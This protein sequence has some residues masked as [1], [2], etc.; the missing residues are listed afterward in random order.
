MQ[1]L[2]ISETA[3]SRIA[4]KWL[5]QPRFPDKD[6]FTSSHLGFVLVTPITAKTQKQQNNVGRLGSSKWK[7]AIEGDWEHP[8][9]TA[10]HQ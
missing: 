10:S 1:N 3:E 7:G 2:Q 6:R 8:S 5:F 9:I 4:L